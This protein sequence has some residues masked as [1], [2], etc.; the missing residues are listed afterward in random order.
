MRT[1]RRGRTFFP[2]TLAGVG[3][4]DSQN[5]AD[6]VGGAGRVTGHL[7]HRRRGRWGGGGYTDR[8]SYTLAKSRSGAS[9]EFRIG[10]VS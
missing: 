7:C 8:C 10:H 5:A 4:A 9:A 3:R 2:L 6:G 1:N